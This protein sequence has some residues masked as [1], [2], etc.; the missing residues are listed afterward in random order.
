MPACCEVLVRIRYAECDAQ[1]VVFNGRYGELA[2][3]AAT[4]LFRHCLGGYQQ[5][6]D[7]G[8]DNQVV[9]YSID[10][11]APIRFDEIICIR[12][13]VE[14]VG[15]TSMRVRIDFEGTGEPGELRAQ[16]E[17]VYVMV[18]A[19]DY[20]KLPIPAWLTALAMADSPAVRIDLAGTAVSKDAQ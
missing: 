20:R 2:D 10:W 16:A 4:E 13:Q 6:L 7:Q 5:M 3:V 19:A 17:L 15:N 9:H 8:L 12:A 11:K 14:R 1:G 18:S